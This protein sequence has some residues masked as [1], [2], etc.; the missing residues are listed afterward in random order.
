MQRDDSGFG[1]TRI[2]FSETDEELARRFDRENDWMD[3]VGAA[4]KQR[5]KEDLILAVPGKISRV[6]FSV[7]DFRWWFG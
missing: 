2:A 5:A 3:G 7:Y 1:D 6:W 4:P